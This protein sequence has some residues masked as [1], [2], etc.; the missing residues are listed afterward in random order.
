MK[1]KINDHI[2]EFKVEDPD[3]FE[4]NHPGCAGITIED[5]KKVLFAEDEFGIDV[6]LHEL[7]HVYRSELCTSAANLTRQ[8]EEEVSAELFAQQAIKMVRL[9]RRIYKELKDG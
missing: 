5:G 8:Q 2:W 1:V 4:R 3:R 6:V 9:A 7:W